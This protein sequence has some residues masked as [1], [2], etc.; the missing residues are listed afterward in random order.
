[1]RNEDDDEEYLRNIGNENENENEIE[2]EGDGDG[3][4]DDND[5]DDEEDEEDVLDA[6]TNNWI[7][8]RQAQAQAQQHTDQQSHVHALT[9]SHVR[10]HGDDSLE[11]LGQHNS[12]N[13]TSSSSSSPQ[14]SRLF[15]SHSFHCTNNI[16]I[17]PNHDPD[18]Q[19][20]SSSA[21][22]TTSYTTSDVQHLNQNRNSSN[23]NHRPR[24]NSQNSRSYEDNSLPSSF[25]SNNISSSS[26]SSSS[27]HSNSLPLFPSSRGNAHSDTPHNT[28]YTH[29][30]PTHS[31]SHTL[32]STHT[33]H[34]MPSSSPLSSPAFQSEKSTDNPDDIDDD[35][36]DEEKENGN[37]TENEIDDIRTELD[38]PKYYNTLLITETHLSQ[39]EII[40]SSDDEKRKKRKTIGVEYQDS[41][42]VQRR[43]RGRA[44]GDAEE[45]FLK[46]TEKSSNNNN[47]ENDNVVPWKFENNFFHGNNFNQN[48]VHDDDKSHL[49]K[50]IETETARN[51][52]SV[53]ESVVPVSSNS[54]ATAASSTNEWTRDD[55]KTE[56]ERK[57]IDHAENYLKYLKY[58]ENSIIIVSDK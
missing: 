30:P 53:P 44:V 12:L 15:P 50:L 22:N 3:T 31:E 47:D 18:T 10:T 2:G 52:V 41:E 6:V 43:E 46:R 4:I 1:M 37:E 21:P 13:S 49:R 32:N 33:I 7:Q 20:S 26:S 48:G 24:S 58:D 40:E 8:Q 28:Q 19:Y 27:Y 39:D 54:T 34:S 17:Y 14:S 29:I 56:N 36:D 51:T 11:I 55:M 57:D 5:E 16:N 38:R 9:Q 35:I 23:Q 42:V 45:E 25:L